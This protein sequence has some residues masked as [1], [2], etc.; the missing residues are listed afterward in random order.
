MPEGRW[1]DFFT[2]QAYTGGLHEICTEN[3]PVFVRENAVIPMAEPVEYITG[4]TCFEITLRIYGQKE[5][6]VCRLAEDEGN[7]GRLLAFS[8]DG[9]FP[10][11]RRYRLKGREYIG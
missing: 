8:A 7:G 3:I 6:A 2:G 10:E 11:S 1:F 5:G 4:R 9:P